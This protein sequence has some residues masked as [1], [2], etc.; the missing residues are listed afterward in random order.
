MSSSARIVEL[1][2]GAVDPM[3]VETIESELVIPLH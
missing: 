1:Y 2:L 3:V